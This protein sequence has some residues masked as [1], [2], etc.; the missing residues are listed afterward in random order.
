MRSIVR[1]L[2]AFDRV[3]TTSTM[4]AQQRPVS[5]SP[6]VS[7]SPRSL[8]PDDFQQSSGD[9]TV[10][11]E[12]ANT[13]ASAPNPTTSGSNASEGKTTPSRWSMSSDV[14]TETIKLKALKELKEVLTPE[15]AYLSY[16]PLCR[17]LGARSIEDSLPNH[18]LL[19]SLCI[20]FDENVQNSQ[21]HRITEGSMLHNSKEASLFPA[22]ASPSSSD[23][24]SASSVTVTGNR[25]DINDSSLNEPEIGQYYP[26]SI[27]FSNSVD[28]STYLSNKMNNTKRHLKGNWLAYWNY[29]I[30]RS[31]QDTSFNLNH[32]KLQSFTGHTNGIKNLLVLDNENSFISCSKDKTVKLW[33]L[34]NEGDGSAQCHPQY[35]Y[36]SHKKSVFGVTFCERHRLVTTCDS[37][38]HVWDPFIGATVRQ[39]DSIRHSPVTVLASMAAPS[40]EVLA[41][42]TDATLRVIDLR[43]REYTHQ[44]KVTSSGAGLVRCVVCSK[45]G[46]LVCVAHSSGIVSVLETRTGNLIASWKPHEG[47]VLCVKWYQGGTFLSSALDQTVAVW[48]INKGTSSN[49][50]LLTGHTEPVHL[51]QLYHHQVITATTANRIGHHTAVAPDAAYTSYRLKSDSLRGVVTAMEVLP[52]NRMMLL[53]ADSGTI[54]L[55]C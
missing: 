55:L 16:Y 26:A 53:G 6:R 28:I 42:T 40:S 41:A 52:L 9:V 20:Q 51:L 1:L 37:T 11:D 38:V 17:F 27:G 47:E 13:E 48:D 12:S 35:T 5:S 18:E 46:R 49:K 31:D 7:T 8:D 30:G 15:L 32:I 44:Y 54:R 22:G 29:E 19:R 25:I 14:S 24:K 34:R 21:A 39:L 43:V 50:Y 4:T 2:T 36:T 10:S 23:P 33:S 3:H 45:D